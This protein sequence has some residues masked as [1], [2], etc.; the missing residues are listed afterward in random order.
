MNPFIY[1]QLHVDSPERA[2]TFY[3]GLFD[4]ETGSPEGAGQNHLEIHYSHPPQSI[5]AGVIMRASSELVAQ[6]IPFVEVEDVDECAA[7]ATS[8][9]GAIVIHPTDV[10]D[11]GRFSILRDP[12]GAAFAVWR[13]S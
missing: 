7:K 1:L 10:P 8:S 11:K 5:R 9:G 2:A 13:A 3:G 6:W 12:C 4:W